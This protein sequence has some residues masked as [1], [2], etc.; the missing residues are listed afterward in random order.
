VSTAIRS[1]RVDLRASADASAAPLTVSVVISAYT[2]ERWDDLVAAVESL[3]RQ[4]C[5]PHQVIVV[6]DHN[7]SLLERVRAHLPDVEAVENTEPRGLSGARNSGIAA[8]EGAIIAFLD[9]DAVA[10]PA[11][12]E[13]LRAGYEDPSVIGVGGAAE[14]WWL[15]GRPRS[16]PPEFDWVVGCTYRGM[17]ETPAR[18]RNFIG[19]NMSFRRAVFESA[20]TFQSG[21]GRIGTRPVGCEETELCIRAQRR[22]PEGVFLFEPAAKI[23]HRVPAQRG[24]WRYFASRCYAEGLSKAVVSQLAGSRDG[25]ASERTYALRTLPRGVAR[26]LAD[27]ALRGDVSGLGRAGAIVGGLCVTTAGYV[28]GTVARRLGRSWGPR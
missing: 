7:P 14:P 19:A 11:W 10:A 15:D 23:A 18:V 2:E 4:T 9:D 5:P 27:A 1:P 20:G 21:I 22:W 17:P 24:T 3:R 6:V 13:R 25:L 26:G 12:I 8:A 28:V 16:F